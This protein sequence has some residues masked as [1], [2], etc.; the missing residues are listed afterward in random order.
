MAR[1]AAL[2]VLFAADLRGELTPEAVETQFDEVAK[3]FSLPGRSRDWALELALGVAKNL[4]E[5]DERIGRASTNWQIHRI[6]PVDR[7]VLRIG[8]YELL[9]ADAPTEVIIDEAVE[10]ARRFAGSTSPAFVNGVLDT[11]AREF[12]GAAAA[13]RTASDS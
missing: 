2:Q 12:A 7:N 8:A 3:E 5:I 4:S 1:E 10:I 13:R 6:A 11:L 9:C